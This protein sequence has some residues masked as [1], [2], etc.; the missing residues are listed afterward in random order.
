[1][2]AS[3]VLVNWFSKNKE[4]SSHKIRDTYYVNRHTHRILAFDVENHPLWQ[5]NTFLSNLKKLEGFPGGAVVKNPPANS[6][7]AGSSPGLGR[8]HMLRSS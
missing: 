8:S 5:K 6:G 1:M 2:I 7:D 3:G 4:A